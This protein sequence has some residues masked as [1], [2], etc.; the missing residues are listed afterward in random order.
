MHRRH[1]CRDDE[2]DSTAWAMAKPRR[3]EQNKNI[4]GAGSQALKLGAASAFPPK[5]GALPRGR[6]LRV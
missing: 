3:F 2:N 1:G 5:I 4:I 6:T